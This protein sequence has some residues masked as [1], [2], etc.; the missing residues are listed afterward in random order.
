MIVKD[1]QYC[2]ICGRPKTQVHHLVFGIALRKLAE[3]DKLVAPICDQCHCAIH[4]NYAAGQMSKMIGQLCYEKT[5]TREE[6]RERYG[7]SYL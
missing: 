2:F 6:F 7:R 5:H 4:E 1:E 3:E